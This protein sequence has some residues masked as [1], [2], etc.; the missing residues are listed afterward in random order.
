MKKE[1]KLCDFCSSASNRGKDCQNWQ[2]ACGTCEFCGKDFCE[3]CEDGGNDGLIGC[4][5]KDKS[6]C[7][8][9]GNDIF[10]YGKSIAKKISPQT[11]E[12]LFKAIKGVL[13]KNG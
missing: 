2:E 5:L 3:D 6:M 13:C 12:D 4:L 7:C 11:I 8:E 10:E 9:C 1:V